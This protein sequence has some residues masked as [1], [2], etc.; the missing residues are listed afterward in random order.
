MDRFSNVDPS[1]RHP[2]SNNTTAQ[3]QTKQ[4]TAAFEKHWRD[5]PQV[6]VANVHPGQAV[7]VS[8]HERIGTRTS[9]LMK[10]N[11]RSPLE[12]AAP[13][14]EGTFGE[15]RPLGRAAD[16]DVEHNGP[17]KRQRIL[18]NPREVA[19]QNLLS[20]I[21]NSGARGLMQAATS[22]PPAF[23]EAQMGRGRINN[24]DAPKKD[25]GDFKRPA[26]QT[27]KSTLVTVGGDKRGLYSNDA[28]LI[29][30]LDSA[31]RKGNVMETTIKLN[32]NPLLNFARWLVAN[33]KPGFATRLDEASLKHDFKQYEAS[34]GPSL[35]A[36][37]RHLKTA[38]AGGVPILGRSVRNPY[39]P[40][41]P[42]IKLHKA[43]PSATLAIVG[44][45]KRAL[46]SKDASLIEVLESALRKGNVTETTVKLNVNPL[47]NFARWLVAN[48]KQG[49][50]S[51]MGE[52]SLTRDFKQYEGSGGPSLEAPMRYLKTA[53][54]GGVPI[55]GRSVRNPYFQDRE[56]IHLYSATPLVK[57]TDAGKA[58][59]YKHALARFSDYLQK[60]GK[61][62][63]A[64]RLNHKTLD[65]D[66]KLYPGDCSTIHAALEHL[67]NS[68]ARQSGSHNAPGSHPEEEMATPVL[69][70]TKPA[71]SA[72]ANSV[73]FGGVQSFV[74]LRAPNPSDL[75]DD[76]HFA[77]GPPPGTRA[78]SGTFGGLQS[79]VDLNAPTPSDLRD[80]AHFAPG[81]PPGARARSGTFGGLQSFV[82]LNAPTPSDLRDDAHF[83]PGPPPGTRARSGT[84]GGLQSFVD[85]NAPT[86]SDL[87]DDAH[88][89]PGPP[90]GTRARSGTFGG[91]QSF[92][93]LNA[94]TP[95]D[96]RD[97]AH[98]AP[99]RPRKQTLGDTERQTMMQGTEAAAV[100][101]PGGPGDGPLMHRGRLSPMGE[102]AP[103]TRAKIRQ[104]ASP[105]TTRPGDTYR[106]LPVVDL[107]TS[108]TTSSDTQ[109]GAS[110]PRASSNVAKGLVLGP[111][112]WL[113]D[114]HILRDYNLLRIPT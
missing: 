47:L 5:L 17:R 8:Q 109:L 57:S 90:P 54:A 14:R 55:G 83:A 85:L 10:G 50:A 34:G 74:D 21:G 66:V 44:R 95:S 13:L 84:F 110:G 76:A 36:P 106:G 68:G 78:R 37:L 51:R 18:D 7:D 71:P 1:R 94:P 48:G 92:V 98:S 61:M 91:L 20:E 39:F 24:P 40:N 64:A 42:L 101:G 38:E 26:D 70:A 29:G 62:S 73:N 11:S 25:L 12:G 88:F 43:T 77:P 31:L 27:Q 23:D 33:G 60:N 81:P 107:T 16:W 86:P 111:D 113:A 82:D 67:R 104:P 22:L 41:E 32:V 69:E 75:G 46:Y 114:E 53:E 80:D 65:D 72:R 30:V 28:S 45:D 35:E 100:F 89:A 63:I 87:R 112:Q 79:F 3:K 99:V 52:T 97:D 9:R 6:D 4:E 96:L 102:A 56:L 59:R 105:V 2:V 49:F 108:T 19:V 103:A 93:D 15:D 58:M